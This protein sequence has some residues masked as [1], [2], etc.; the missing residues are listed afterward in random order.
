M[1]ER[2]HI[3]YYYKVLAW[4][5]YFLLSAIKTRKI[6]TFSPLRGGGGG[7]GGFLFSSSGVINKNHRKSQ[8]PVFW[9][10]PSAIKTYDS[11]NPMSL[12]K[13]LVKSTKIT[14]R[15]MN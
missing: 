7:R 13:R 3:R 1:K 10:N 9:D 2:F 4:L 12:F 8:F 11:S 6:E 5:C 14:K 15:E